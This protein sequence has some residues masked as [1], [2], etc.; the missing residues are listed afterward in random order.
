MELIHN[1]LLIHD[2][3]ID[4]SDMRRG[5][6]TVHKKLGRKD[7]HYGV[8]QAIVIGDISAFEAVKLLNESDFSDEVKIEVM[9]L[10]TGVILETAYG[11]ILDVEYASKRP[12]L[13]KV[14]LV[15]EL[16]T[17]KYSFVGPLKLGALLSGASKSQLQ[18]L[19]KYGLSLGKAFQLQDDILGV[20]ADEKTL[21]KSTLSDMRE[22]KNTVLFY[23]TRKLATGSQRRIIDRLWG[24]SKSD[25][26]DLDVVREI[27]RESGALNW[28]YKET[29][30]LVN[31]AKKSIDKIT[32]EKRPA[33]ILSQCADFVIERDR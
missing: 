6:P 19:E 14:W 15:T 4:K 27:M 9:D 5:K 18:A 21:G 20:F 29:E 13:D 28:C 30:K 26:S 25:A 11:E 23:K 22:G 7:E 10:F 31:N 3:I 2:D 24:D 8:S 12:K 32:E 17:A 33:T 16:K 1:F